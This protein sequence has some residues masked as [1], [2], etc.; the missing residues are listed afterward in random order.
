M[1]LCISGST[2]SEANKVHSGIWPTEP[3]NQPSWAA[4]CGQCC[5]PMRRARTGCGHLVRRGRDARS[6]AL[7][8]GSPVDHRSPRLGYTSYMVDGR[9]RYTR[10]DG[11]GMGDGGSTGRQKRTNCDEVFTVDRM[12]P[13]VAST[14]R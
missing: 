5:S 7:T 4:C 11:K 6:S 10:T 2:R 14:W 3:T 1:T 13:T 8:D 9:R 12:A